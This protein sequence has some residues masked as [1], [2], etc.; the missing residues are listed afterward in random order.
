[1]NK[2]LYISYIDT[3][4]KNGVYLREF[5]FLNFL[6]K[7][8]KV[9]YFNVNSSVKNIDLYL[10]ENNFEVTRLILRKFKNL[11]IL[12]L[13]RLNYYLNYILANKFKLYTNSKLFFKI[14]HTYFKQFRNIVSFYS[15]P[16]HFLSLEKLKDSKIII[17]T[18]DIMMNRHKLTNSTS[19][20][21][22]SEKLERKLCQENNL[23]LFISNN[24]R[25]NYQKLNFCD[26]KIVPFDLKFNMINKTS[27]RKIGFI[28][29]NS[30]FNYSSSLELIDLAKKYKELKFIISGSVVEKINEFDLPSNVELFYSKDFSNKFLEEYYS[31]VSISYLPAQNNSGIKTKIIESLS[32]SVPVITNKNG[33]DNTFD[34]FLNKYIF[35]AEDNFNIKKIIEKKFVDKEL[36]NLYNK[37]KENNYKSFEEV[38]N[39]FN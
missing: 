3:T 21:S 26:G 5:Q 38:I 39:F 23:L 33:Y 36:A 7:H 13:F 24:D 15:I 1:M 25:I 29:S 37:Y 19:W 2:I 17:D 10:K 4:T 11:K 12:F 14:N 8:Y 20:W 16:F 6:S 31:K 32:Y 30:I 34:L 22:F 9:Y 28:G 18:C 27:C 35:V